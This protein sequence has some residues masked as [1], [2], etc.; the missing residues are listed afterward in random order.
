MTGICRVSTTG[1]CIRRKRR[2]KTVIL[3]CA[4]AFEEGQPGE[5]RS[6]EQ[7]EAGGPR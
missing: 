6:G 7:A 4:G 5:Q 1:N 3:L 2:R